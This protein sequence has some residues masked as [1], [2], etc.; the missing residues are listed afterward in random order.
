MNTLSAGFLGGKIKEKLSHTYHTGCLIHNNHSARA[1]NCARSTER[2][3]VDYCVK[4][5]CGNTAAG[6]TAHLN[7]FEFLAVLYSAA[8]VKYNVSERFAHRY[9]NKT[10]LFNLTR[11]SKNLCTLAAL[12]AHSGK[13]LAAV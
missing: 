4:K 3:I 9:F 1:H 13:G 7:S 6:R 2:L 11:E 5:L 10:A 12:R 8:D